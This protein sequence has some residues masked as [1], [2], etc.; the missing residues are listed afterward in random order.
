MTDPIR[1]L[2]AR[3]VEAINREAASGLITRD[4]I[5]LAALVQ[6]QLERK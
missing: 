6:Q 2:A 1:P 4:I 5:A 3:L